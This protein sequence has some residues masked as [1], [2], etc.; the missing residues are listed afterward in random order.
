MTGWRPI[1]TAPKDGTRV[2]LLDGGHPT[3]GGFEVIERYRHGELESRLEYWL[4]PGWGTASVEPTHWMPLPPLPGDSP[5]SRNVRRSVA[6]EN[7]ATPYFHRLLAGAEPRWR[8]ALRHVRAWLG[9]SR[10]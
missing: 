6:A 8:K 9:R 10:D 2:I 7:E 4:V 1:E 3:V 5:R